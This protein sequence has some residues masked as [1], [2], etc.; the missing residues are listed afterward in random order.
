VLA[1][2]EIA[3]QHVRAMELSIVVRILRSMYIIGLG[4]KLEEAGKGKLKN[5]ASGVASFHRF[6]SP[7][8]QKERPL[9]FLYYP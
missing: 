8:L 3:V 6:V 1:A 7:G 5:S 9:P 4:R 2:T